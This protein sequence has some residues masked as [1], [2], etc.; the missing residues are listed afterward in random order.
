MEGKR[1]ASIKNTD[2]YTYQYSM[3]WLSKS[4]LPSTGMEY[5]MLKSA[6]DAQRV[7]K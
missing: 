5:R 1:N 4:G 2:E 3:D 6:F 7:T